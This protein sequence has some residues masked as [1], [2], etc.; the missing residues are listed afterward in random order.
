MSDPADLRQRL[1]GLS[2]AQRAQLAQRLVAGRTASPTPVDRTLP[3]AAP[4]RV[5]SEPDVTV[6]PASHGQ[7]RM[8]FLHQY[9]EGAPV[10]CSPS[11]FHLTGPLNLAALHAAFTDLV[12]RHDTLRTTFAAVDG[13]LFQRVAACADFR[14]DEVSL[15]SVPRADQHAAARLRLETEACRPFDLAAAPAFRVVLLKLQPDEY[16]LLVLLHHIVSDGWSRSN[17]WRDL[18]AFYHAHVTGQPSTLRPLPVQFADYAAWQEAWL[19]EGAG[20]A[21]AEYW[22]SKLA[23]EPD[24]LELPA[25]R[26]RPP[27]ESFR[28]ARAMLPLDPALTAALTKRAQ[29]EGATLFMILMAAFNTLLHRY[30]GHTDLLV[31]VPIANRPRVEV[32]GLIGFFSNTLVIRTALG[33]QPTFPEVLRRVKQASIEAYERQDMPFERLV[34]LLQVRRDASRTPLFQTLFNLLDFPGVTFPIPD[35]TAVPW[36]VS[37]HTAKFDLS[38]AVERSAD[39]WVTTVEYSCDLFDADRINRM[40]GHWRTLLE[41]IVEDPRRLLAELPLLPVDERNALFAEHNT[42]SPHDGS[43]C[44]HHLFEAQARR[45]PDAVAVEM[46][47]RHLTYREL[48]D[49]ADAVANHL[50][51]S[52]VASGSRVGI[53]L[54]RSPD[55]VVCLL[56]ILKAGAAYVPLDPHFPQARLALI[57]ED[58]EVGMLITEHALSECCATFQGPRWWWDEGMPR[59]S[60]TSSPVN[61][62]PHDA[63]YIIYTSGSTGHPKGVVLEHRSVVN[64]LHSMRIRPGLD[65]DDIL[66]AVTTVSFDIS[67]VE[68]FLPLMVGARVVLVPDE[69]RADGAGLAALLKASRATVF[70]ATPATWKLLVQAGWPGDGK[71]KAWCGGEAL[72]PD[73]AT[74]LLSRCRE[75]WNLYGPTETTVYS[76]LTRITTADDI[77]IG[78]PV[79]NTPV[80]VV[81][82]AGQVLPVGIPG[83]LWIGGEGLARGY[84]KRPDLTADRFPPDPFC[85]EL[86]ARVYRTGDRCCRLS[87]GRIA[88]LGRMDNQIKLRGFRVELGEIESALRD[89]THAAEVVVSL[90][91]DVAGEKRLV[92]YVVTADG[93]PP[94][95]SGLRSALRERLPDYM[96][97][98][99]IVGL[100]ALPLTPNRKV[101]RRALPEP[102]YLAPGEERTDTPRDL[103]EWR[104]TQLWEQLFQRGNIGRDDNFFDLGGHSLLAARLA[105]Q[106]ETLL[107]RRVPIAAFFQAPTISQLAEMLRREDWAPAWSSLV[108]LKPAGGQPPLFLIHGWGGDVFCFVDLARELNVDRSIFGVQAVGLDGRRPRHTTVEEMAAHYAAEILSV[109]PDGPYHLAG[110]SLG[111]WIAYAVAQELTRRGGRV[112]FLGLL[113]TRATANVSWPV[114]LRVLIPYVFDRTA[115]HLTRWWSL[116]SEAKRQYLTGR[117]HALSR[118]LSRARRN[119]PARVGPLQ[120]LAQGASADL[121]TSLPPATNRRCMPATRTCLWPPKP[122]PIN[123][124]F[125]NN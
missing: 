24:P 55:L 35:V 70:Q 104:L 88:F 5:E 114:Y 116:P 38:F 25:D 110:Y 9:A 10:Y 119:E 34:D 53:C 91:D 71:L 32:E 31:G 64:L 48:N 59:P 50:T 15:E 43:L 103:L 97:P 122:V 86:G 76:L 49:H 90:R 123:M 79:A 16:V 89:L 54:G 98:A 74:L 95:D 108:P 94:D 115:H 80:Y 28:G 33:D 29:E 78:T 56:G 72:P 8:W 30:T 2:P 45:T 1:A 40:L 77:T 3:C 107:G 66:L 23:G 46:S 4:L 82:T 52:G 41:G 14:W 84:W 92:A 81:D 57:L 105:G 22:K 99:R 120:A 44:L 13:G 47:D 112:A 83:E 18:A 17:L 102:E 60:A 65:A 87:D 37:T 6:Y 68:L 42:R 69:L 58:A 62:A 7:R 109:Q 36:L 118:H 100:S 121:S 20:A 11:A 67:V 73:L 63:A 75:L 12:A 111:G 85:S 19:A 96:V 117:W 61:V 113:D 27:T 93:T 124:D 26:P 21:Q 106:V 101:D 39:G 125:G 51:A